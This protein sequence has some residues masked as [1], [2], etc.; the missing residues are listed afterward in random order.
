MKDRKGANLDER[1]GGKELGRVEG[2]KTITMIYYYV[3]K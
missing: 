1:G 3:R 2:G